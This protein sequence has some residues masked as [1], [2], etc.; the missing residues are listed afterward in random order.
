MYRVYP[1]MKDKLPKKVDYWEYI[2]LGIS[3]NL[4]KETL[5]ASFNS[6]IGFEG[7]PM[8]VFER[9]EAEIFENGVRME[10]NLQEFERRS[11]GSTG[12]AGGISFNPT[13]YKRELWH[14]VKSWYS[15][16]QYPQM[17]S[18][19]DNSPLAKSHQGL[20]HQIIWANLRFSLGGRINWDKYTFRY[21]HPTIIYRLL[22]D[23]GTGGYTKIGDSKVAYREGKYSHLLL[24]DDS[25]YIA[26]RS[27][28]TSL[29]ALKDERYYEVLFDPVH[30]AEMSPEQFG[31]EL[32]S[33]LC[34]AYIAYELAIEGRIIPSVKAQLDAVNWYEGRFADLLAYYAEVKGLSLDALRTTYVREQKEILLRVLHDSEPRKLERLLW[35]TLGLNK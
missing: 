6:T 17:G 28:N 31:T 19:T 32:V 24:P 2:G 14:R 13:R 27:E 18:G 11:C 7:V 12:Y 5:E 26:D 10:F 23:V 35:Q 4:K 16:R 29:M 33:R 34:Q 25:R 21:Y 20:L 8:E 9:V 30:L 1:Y 3:C 22:V 15:E